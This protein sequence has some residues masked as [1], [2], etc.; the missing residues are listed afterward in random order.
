MSTRAT[1]TFEVKSWDEKTY[2]ELEGAGKLTRASVAYSYKGE[3]EGEGQEEFLMMYPDE[4]S[5][6]FVEMQRIVGSVGGRSGSFV[7]QGSGT[8]EGGAAKGTWSVVPGSGTGELPI[9]TAVEM[10]WPRMSRLSILGRHSSNRIFTALQ[11]TGGLCT[12]PV[13]Q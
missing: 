4:K 8:F 12:A 7:L 2:E 9:S 6:S 10:L 11:L 1:G 13:P 5:A 3:I